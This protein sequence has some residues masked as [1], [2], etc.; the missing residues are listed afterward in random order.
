MTKCIIRM[1]SGE[2]M[3][4][5][6]FPEAAP[7]TVA[8]FADLANRGFYDG[9]GFCRIVEGYVIQGG[10]VDD[11]IMTDSDFH[12]FGEFAE[13][14][15]DTG[16]RHVRGA[17]S[18]ARDEGMNTAG[19]Q[20]FIVHRDAPKLDGR[21]AAFGILREGFDVLGRIAQAPTEGAEKWNRPLKMPVMQSVRVSSDTPLP[22]VQRLP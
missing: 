15:M 9:L 2:S 19:T 10:S 1:A 16:L 12:L 13:N 6:L 11:Q 5:E 14:G 8:N 4:L 7:L 22:P 21:Y 3:T 20:F 18:M 17:I